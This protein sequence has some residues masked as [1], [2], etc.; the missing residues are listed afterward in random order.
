MGAT[1]MPLVR[2]CASVCVCKCMCVYVLVH[3]CVN[4]SSMD[5]IHPM[6]KVAASVFGGQ[7]MYLKVGPQICQDT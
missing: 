2:V 3:V 4:V 5:V 1:L 7:S 6:I